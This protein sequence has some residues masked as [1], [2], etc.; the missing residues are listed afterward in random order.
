MQVTVNGKEVTIFSGAKV[1]D[2][3]RRYSM[4]EYKQIKGGDKIV[5]DKY[6]NQIMLGGELTGREELIITSKEEA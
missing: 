1:E 3:I 2:V 5:K 4:D 6:G